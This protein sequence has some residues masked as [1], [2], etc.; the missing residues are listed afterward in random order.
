MAYMVSETAT[1]LN[2]SRNIMCQVYRS[3]L[4][5]IL[6]VISHI[7]VDFFRTSQSDLSETADVPL[8]SS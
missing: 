8:A 6:T 5:Q 1:S 2:S 4:W 7:C 3:D